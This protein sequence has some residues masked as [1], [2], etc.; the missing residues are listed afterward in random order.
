M[1]LPARPGS[2][3]ID[4]NDLAVLA[5]GTV[6]W[7]IQPTRGSHALPWNALRYFGPTVNRFDPHPPPPRVHAD[8]AVSY[9]AL[10]PY[11]TFAEVYQRGRAINR[12]AGNPFLTAWRINRPLRLLDLTGAWPAANGA[13]HAINTGRHDHCRAW[14]HAIH[15]HPAH[16]D[17]LLHTSAMAGSRAVTLFTPAVDSF[18]AAPE[19]TRSLTDPALEPL[20]TAAA[21]RFNYRVTP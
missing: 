2:L 21:A 6:L 3:T 8:Y 19:F 16:V 15:D 1:K 13:S 18:P 4:P 9:T 20:I 7:R 12:S 5:E 11:T 17:G 10:D 14:A